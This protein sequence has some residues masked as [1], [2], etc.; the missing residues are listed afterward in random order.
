[1]DEERGQRKERIWSKFGRC[2]YIIII[3]P[4][5]FVTKNK[6]N[7]KILKIIKCR[8]VCNMDVQLRSNS[9]VFYSIQSWIILSNRDGYGWE[10]Q[11]EAQLD[12][13]TSH[14]VLAHIRAVYFW[15]KHDK[16]LRD[17]T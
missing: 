2:V 4:S 16:I 14:E 8:C 5:K 1:M 17:L 13:S 6:I 9:T 11:T 15:K 7:V 10:A 12:T 3:L